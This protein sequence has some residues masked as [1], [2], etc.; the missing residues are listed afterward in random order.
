MKLNKNSGGVDA[1]AGA[2][3]GGEISAQARKDKKEGIIHL[4]E[5]RTVI[6]TA[7]LSRRLICDIR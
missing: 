7:A 2:G 3:G 5:R 4:K 1:G 6:K